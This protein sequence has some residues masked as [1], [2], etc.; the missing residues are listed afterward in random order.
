[1]NTYYLRC[2]ASHYS[3]LV[4][5]G[6][7]MGAIQQLYGQICPVGN[8]CWDYIGVKV[9][10][11]SVETPNPEPVGGAEDPFV[12]VNF[13]TE[14][15]LRSLAMAAAMAGDTDIAAGMSEIA[16]YF[17]TDENGNAAAP[18]VPLRVFL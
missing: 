11:S 9:P 12:H 15:D 16:S 13:R 14:H 18:N 10:E 6:I 7:R 1:M 5:R 17:I 2:R 3:T 4:A 8:G